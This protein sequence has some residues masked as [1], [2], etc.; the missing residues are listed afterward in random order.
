MKLFEDCYELC[1][2]EGF[3]FYTLKIGTPI[4]AGNLYGVI[5]DVLITLDKRI[6]YVVESEGI[7]E[8]QIV[9]IQS[10]FVVPYKSIGNI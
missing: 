8:G 6:I 10:E 9:R 7:T 4:V 1:T 5:L 3:K 2:I